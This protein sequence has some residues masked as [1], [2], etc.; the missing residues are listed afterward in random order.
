[1]GPR[2]RSNKI[3]SKEK[4]K[5]TNNNR[6]RQKRKHI[7]KLYNLYLYHTKITQKNRNA[8]NVVDFIHPSIHT[9]IHIPEGISIRKKL[10]KIHKKQILF[11]TILTILKLPQQI[12]YSFT[13]CTNIFHS[14]MQ[15]LCLQHNCNTLKRQCRITIFMIA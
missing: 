10:Y 8:T 15:F 5:N 7:K 4:I 14:I 11:T 6:K 9:Y 2:H 1:M 13:C 12:N 3:R